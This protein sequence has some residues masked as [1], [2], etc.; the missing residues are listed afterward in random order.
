LDPAEL[1]HRFAYHPPKDDAT[2]YAH[3]KVR[4]IF[5]HVAVQMNDDLPEGREK[6]LVMTHLEDAMMWANASIARAGGN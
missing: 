6:S 1:A 4:E 2:K 3:E 5:G